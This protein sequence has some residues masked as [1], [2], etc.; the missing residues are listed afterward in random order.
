MTIDDALIR[1]NQLKEDWGGNEP[2]FL[3]DRRDNRLFN[4][5][6]LGHNDMCPPTGKIYIGYGYNQNASIDIFDDFWD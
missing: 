1:L 5:R 4:E 3:V 2:L 6:P